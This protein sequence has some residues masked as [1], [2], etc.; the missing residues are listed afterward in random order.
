MT[1]T[2]EARSTG[3]ATVVC[4]R[5]SARISDASASRNSAGGRWRRQAGTA[6]T[7]AASVGTP[8]KRTALRAARGASRRWYAAAASGTAAS[9]ASRPGLAKLIA[10]SAPARAASR[11][12]WRARRARRPTRRRSAATIARRARSRA[13]VALAQPA[14][15]AVHVEAAPGLGVDQREVS[16]GGQGAL[17]RVAHLHGQHRVARAERGHGRDARIAGRGSPRS[18]RSG[19]SAWR[20][21]PCGRARGQ[22]R[23]RRR[24]RPWPRPPRARAGRPRARCG[25]RGAAAAARAARRMWPPPRARRGGWPAG[26]R[27]VPR[28]R[29]R[30]T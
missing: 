11:R 23:R 2:T 17:A 4:G 9:T 10:A 20:L 27:A 26:P 19:R 14:V 6:G 24:G 15:R 5:A 21:G 18:R 22:A 13:L 25:R 16:G 12:R 3:T 8:G 28:P 29:R 1:S 30:R 7:I